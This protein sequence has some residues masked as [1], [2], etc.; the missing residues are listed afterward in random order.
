MENNEQKIENNS[1]CAKCGGLCCQKSGCGFIVS[2][3]K[4]FK[5]AD[6]KA[7]LDEG[8]I[9]IKAV[10]TPYRANKMTM[11]LKMRS[12]DKEVVDLFS[13][14][15]ACKLWTREKGCPLPLELR[16]SLGAGLIPDLQEECSRN[17]YDI[18]EVI[19]DWEKHQ[20]SLAKFVKIYTGKKARDVYEE[21]IEVTCYKVYK[22]FLKDR[23]SLTLGESEILKSI[24]CMETEFKDVILLGKYRAIKE[25]N[26]EKI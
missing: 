1:L 23:K 6:M 18:E 17:L 10:F 21:Q 26:E 5:F 9:S 13:A 8:N 25:L 4:S 12:V 22:K 19:N 11:V 20:D 16:P 15:T 7:L 3:I 2:D 24:P 14:S